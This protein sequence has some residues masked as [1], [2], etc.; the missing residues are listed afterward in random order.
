MRKKSIAE[1]FSADWAA[2]FK[3][4][5]A[6]DTQVPRDVGSMIIAASVKRDGSD[7][8]YPGGSRFTFEDGSVLELSGA[9]GVATAT[10]AT[11]KAK[12]SGR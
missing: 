3:R 5:L 12:K 10:P 1:K 4:M 6:G 11:R 2:A 7:K 8:L 9:A